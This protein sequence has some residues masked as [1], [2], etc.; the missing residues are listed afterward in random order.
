ML[1]GC[2]SDSNENLDEHAKARFAIELTLCELNL[3]RADPPNSCLQLDSTDQVA[4]CIA[5]LE[6]RPQ[7]WTS[8]SGYFRDVIRM[9]HVARRDVELRI[10]LETHE[11]LTKSASNLARILQGYVSLF[12]ASQ[13]QATALRDAL[14][15]AFDTTQSRTTQL[16]DDLF[17]ASVKLQKHASELEGLS[18]QVKRSI[19]MFGKA[20]FSTID[21]LR[22][23]AV[24]LNTDLNHAAR[25]EGVKAL[26][27]LSQF[28]SDRLEQTSLQFNS[29][30]AM[31]EERMTTSNDISFHLREQLTE[32]KGLSN[33]VH[34]QLQEH[35]TM[36]R[37]VDLLMSTV[38]TMSQNVA[39]NVKDSNHS[40]AELSASLDNQQIALTHAIDRQEQLLAEM[41]KL[42]NATLPAGIARS[43]VPEICEHRRVACAFLLACIPLLSRQALI[44]A[45]LGSAAV[46]AL[47][48]NIPEY[49]EVIIIV[50]ELFAL[51][52]V[53]WQLLKILPNTTR[54]LT[55][56]ILRQPQQKVLKDDDEFEYLFRTPL[57]SPLPWTSQQQ[58]SVRPSVS[59]NSLAEDREQE[60]EHSSD[61]IELLDL[62]IEQSQQRRTPQRRS[63]ETMRVLA[64]IASSSGS[65]WS[66]DDN[67]EP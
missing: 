67:G 26:A 1:H 43:L 34:A 15:S 33:E 58:H 21:D 52:V 47:W 28:G 36:M 7:F 64:L 37:Q 3:A 56:L 11:N 5:E 16:D 46:T 55:S 49:G 18:E 42:L 19:N 12:D 23:H 20:A 45:L 17:R 24:Q 39:K 53:V 27:A 13:D 65:E 22:H 6:T 48:P 10:A 31:I 4:T 9:C 35:E 40:A 38:S 63:S 62:E 50:L 60:S 44:R 61:A 51:G 30:A 14:Q 8:F 66:R 2:A 41:S 54:W 25:E 57:P 29:F 59:R 32:S